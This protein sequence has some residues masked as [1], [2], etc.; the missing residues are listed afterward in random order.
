M[1]ITV[2]VPHGILAEIFQIK[3]IFT[4]DSH[5]AYLPCKGQRNSDRWKIQSCEAIFPKRNTFLSG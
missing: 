3:T 1:C 2:D 5:D 4:K